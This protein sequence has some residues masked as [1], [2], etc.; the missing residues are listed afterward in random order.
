V[1][2]PHPVGKA[3]SS[4]E[5][6]CGEAKF[7]CQVHPGDA[8][9]VFCSDPSGWAGNAATDIE[10]VI[11]RLWLHHRDEFLGRNDASPVKMIDRREGIWSDCNVRS[12]D[13]SK[14]GQHA[15]GDAFTRVMTLDL[16]PVGQLDLRR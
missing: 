12:G 14:R 11:A 2:D 7:W 9:P 10:Q 8:A 13:I 16:A 6:T 15:R 3:G 5:L 4:I 1:Q